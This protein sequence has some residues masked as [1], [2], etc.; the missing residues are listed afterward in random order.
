VRVEPGT[1]DRLTLTKALT[2]HQKRAK[3]SPSDV[4]DLVDY[5]GK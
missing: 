2:R 3:L 5:L 1:R 4:R